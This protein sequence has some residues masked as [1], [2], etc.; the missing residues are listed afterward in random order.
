[1]L[2]RSRDLIFSG[3]SQVAEVG[4]LT[5]RRSLGTVFDS[6]SLKELLRPQLMREGGEKFGRHVREDFAELD[7]AFG[8]V[9]E[10]HILYDNRVANELLDEGA[11]KA[12]ERRIGN[13]IDRASRLSTLVSCMKTIQ[14]GLEKM[15]L[16]SAAGTLKRMA[17]EPN[18]KKVLKAAE[19]D[20]A[21]WSDGFLEREL[22]P[23]MRE[24]PGAA[25]YDGRTVRTFD[26][27]KMPAEMQSRVVTGLQRLAYADIQRSYLGELPKFIHG[28]IGKTVA[29][30]RNFQIASLE[31]QLIHGIRHDHAAMAML[32]LH[33]T[34]T[35]GAATV[36]KAA[37]RRLGEEDGFEKFLD[38]LDPTDPKFFWS[39]FQNIGLFASLGIATDLMY[40]LGVIPEHYAEVGGFRT[41]S[42]TSIPVV[43]YARDVARVPKTLFN[44]M[45]G[46]GVGES[47]SEDEGQKFLKALHKAVPG[48]NAIGI[49]QAL[50]VLE[51]D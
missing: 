28:T 13:V 3:A 11:S 9:G 36:L 48:L 2:F 41:M 40:S 6:M 51:R 47:D 32:A 17:H 14:S 50:D 38:D 49:N 35:A 5:A 34:F 24:N 20:R 18:F 27:E 33:T 10:D 42:S 44:L 12:W 23:W 46:E 1:M 7:E 25:M 22:F 29:Q 37:H 19:I 16:R 26:F 30:H 43:G 45:Q 21:G 8:F 4:V 31:K 39:V 15:A